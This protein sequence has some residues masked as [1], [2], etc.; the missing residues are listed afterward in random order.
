MKSY[1]SLNPFMVLLF[2]VITLLWGCNG[3]DFDTDSYLW[4]MADE[5][6][7]NE[8]ANDGS[9]AQFSLVEDNQRLGGHKVEVI[10]SGS[11]DQT[12]LELELT[13]ERL[14]KWINQKKVE[15]NVYR[16]S[17][18]TLNPTDFFVGM[19][20]ETDGWDWIDGISWIQ[21]DLESGWN[22]IS[23]EL[24]EHMSEL[25]SDGKYRIYMFFQTHLPPQEDGV[26]LPLHE[27]F[28]ID[29]IRMRSNEDN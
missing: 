21:A 19:A 13:G 17:E 29:G 25:K 2:F 9:G 28:Y 14:E 22:T 10:P 24:P 23:F 18:N 8:Y 11:S 5:T 6:E 12:A 15:V 27:S 26:F 7:V 4:S 16:P 1:N 20:D 3:Q